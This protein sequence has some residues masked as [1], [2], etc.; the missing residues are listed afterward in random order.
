MPKLES[1]CSKDF[2]LKDNARYKAIDFLPTLGFFTNL[3]RNY[4]WREPPKS[5]TQE[6]KKYV[7][8]MPFYSIYQ[9]LSSST[10]YVI[11]DN[12]IRNLK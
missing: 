8:Q 1:L 3:F 7:R 6:Q 4:S 5:S 2:Y 9:G 12:F 11:I 10:A